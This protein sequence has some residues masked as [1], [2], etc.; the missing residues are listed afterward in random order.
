MFF[1]IVS[2]FLQQRYVLTSRPYVR[3]GLSVGSPCRRSAL[4]SYEPLLV[5]AGVLRRRLCMVYVFEL[6][7]SSPLVALPRLDLEFFFQPSRALGGS[8]L[9]V[10][11]RK[12]DVQSPRI[13]LA[14]AWPR[15]EKRMHLLPVVSV[16]V[17]NS[18]GV[19]LAS[20][21]AGEGPA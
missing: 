8:R 15:V 3:L 14:R 10:R 18:E 1:A 17:G 5:R 4:P 2:E 11:A 19:L 13:A 6:P 16:E 21:L 9:R 12:R 7:R 20:G